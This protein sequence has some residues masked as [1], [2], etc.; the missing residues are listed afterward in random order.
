[1]YDRHQFPSRST[2]HAIVMF[3]I[4]AYRFFFVK[5]NH[6][7]TSEELCISNIFLYKIKQSILFHTRTWCEL[8]TLSI[9]KFSQLQLYSIKQLHIELKVYT[10]NIC[11]AV[12]NNSNSL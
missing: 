3:F 6:K 9:E 5:T 7:T 2:C 8:S 1:M 4:Y 10:L 12:Y 11:D